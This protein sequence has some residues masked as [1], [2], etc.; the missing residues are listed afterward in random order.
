MAKKSS[1]LSINRATVDRV[2]SFTGLLI[3]IGLLF[4]SVALTWTHAF[5]HGQ[6]SDQLS[7][8]R[9]FLPAEDS[10]AFTSLSDEDQAAISPYAGQQVTTGA[11]AAVFANHYIAA[12]IKDMGGGKTYSELSNESRA[13]P[14]DTALAAK[15]DSVFRGESLR[16]TLLNAYAF[17]TMAVVAQIAA[18]VAAILAAFFLLL[19][20]LG[21]RHAKHA[22]RST[23]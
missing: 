19:S 15:V 11:A 20:L 1:S 13:N 22:S 6:V 12:H 2:V 17:D 18:V 3:A 14:D 4:A 8:Q 16:G 7:A 10:P 5:I 9:I 21:F 23:R